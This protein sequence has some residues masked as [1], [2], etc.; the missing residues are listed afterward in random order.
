MAAAGAFISLKKVKRVNTLKGFFEFFGVLAAVSVGF[1]GDMSALL[2]KCAMPF[3]KRFAFPLALAENYEKTKELESAWTEC[4]RQYSEYLTDG[5][6]TMLT[7]FVSVFD[8]FSK[9]EFY[10]K[11]KNYEQKFFEFFTEAEEKHKKNGK[12]TVAFSSLLAA[13]VFIIL[14]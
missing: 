6:K 13:L 2:K 12:L 9:R 7:D 10:D 5:E 1:L 8:G 4:V 14:I 11:S 3:N